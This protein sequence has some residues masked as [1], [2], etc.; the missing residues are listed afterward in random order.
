[1]K[2]CV[3]KETSPKNKNLQ[4]QTSIY[5]L[6]VGNS[7]DNALKLWK[8]KEMCKFDWLTWRTT[9]PIWDQ[10]PPH[11][12]LHIRYLSNLVLAIS[13]VIQIRVTPEQSRTN[14]TQ[15]HR[16]SRSMDEFWIL[17]SGSQRHTVR[18]FHETK[19]FWQPITGSCL[20]CGIRHKGHN[21]YASGLNVQARMSTG[22][23]QLYNHQNS[24]TLAGLK[25]KLDL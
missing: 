14:T 24:L 22:S 13:M 23:I 8:K 4:N 19:G 6:L 18:Y 5:I 17:G 11:P 7:S 9:S 25:L 20:T 2:T 3:V 16:F 15:A 10:V 1:M 12:N 21:P